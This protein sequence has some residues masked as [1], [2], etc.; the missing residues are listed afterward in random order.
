MRTSKRRSK[1][2]PKKAKS[3]KGKSVSGP[4]DPE[5][6]SWNNLP[7]KQN[8]YL[9]IMREIIQAPSLGTTYLESDKEARKAFEK[10]GMNVPADVKVVFLPAGDSNKLGAGS[11]VIELPPTDHSKA[12]PSNAE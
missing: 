2:K 11:A 10:F 9:K 5:G 4:R 8:V 12:A 6:I 1:G 7:E 3:S